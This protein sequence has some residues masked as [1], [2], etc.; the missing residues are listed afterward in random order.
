MVIKAVKSTPL[1][2][3][4]NLWETLETRMANIYSRW[5]AEHQY[6]SFESYTETM[7]SWL[8]AGYTLIKA[9][10]RPFGLTVKMPSGWTILI[11]IKS[12]AYTWK[13]VG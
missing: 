2:E 6:E 13:R 4:N 10:S 5:L 7:K 11:T 3:A 1:D 8:P 9:S 12:R